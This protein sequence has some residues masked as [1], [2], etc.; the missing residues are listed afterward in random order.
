M[1]AMTTLRR[2]FC[3]HQWRVTRFQALVS[4]V[5]YECTKCGKM[6]QATPAGRKALEE[7]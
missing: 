5:S 3:R 7:G 1:K 2:F 6:V 4:G